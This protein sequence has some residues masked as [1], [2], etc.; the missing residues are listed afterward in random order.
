M[1][2]G[3]AHATVKLRVEGDRA[4]WACDA[5]ATPFAPA[6]AA[7]PTPVDAPA[8][9]EHL[10]VA[11]FAAATRLHPGTVRNM[12]SSGKFRLGVHYDKRGGNGR[13]LFRRAAVD[14]YLGIQARAS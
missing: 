7:P 13:P 12:M 4:W 9:P 6:A 11:E 1:T 3:C 2:P 14:E 8:L 10:T 5:C